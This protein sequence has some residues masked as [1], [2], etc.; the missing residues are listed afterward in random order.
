MEYFI[1]DV[2][3]FK[4]TGENGTNISEYV[5]TVNR[6]LEVIILFLKS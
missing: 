3:G 1:V 2:S 5:I 4:I 6:S